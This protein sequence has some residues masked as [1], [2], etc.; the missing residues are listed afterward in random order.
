MLA[1]SIE[2][3]ITADRPGWLALREALRPYASRAE[4]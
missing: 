2:P 4:S 3:C 1:L